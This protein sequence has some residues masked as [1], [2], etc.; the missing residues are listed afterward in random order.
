MR[1]AVAACGSLWQ[2]GG[3]SSSG[4]GGG[5][6]CLRTILDCECVAYQIACSGGVPEDTCRQHHCLSAVVATLTS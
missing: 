3:T 1:Q 6:T 4:N 2:G 5:A